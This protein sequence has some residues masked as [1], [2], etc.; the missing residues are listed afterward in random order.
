MFFERAHD[1]FLNKLH[2]DFMER[3][4]VD[5]CNIRIESFKIMDQELS[6]QISKH[7]LTTAQI[8][9]EMAN[10]EGKS[11][12]STTQE[13]TAADVKNINAQAEAEACKTHADAENQRKIEKAK[14]DAEALRIAAQSK[15][16]MEAEA[17]LTKA[18]ATA[19]A[20]RLKAA[21][22]AQRAEMLSNTTLGQQEALLAIY[23]DMVDSW[24]RSR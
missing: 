4:G 12:I 13:R 9:N 19:E 3:Y 8:E 11:L 16:E 14:T 6:E 24:Y 22:E 21:A 5:I 18:K 15:A 17:I 1:E 2:D 23:K 20:I 7:A 10:L